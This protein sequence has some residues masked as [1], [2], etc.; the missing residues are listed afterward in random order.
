[1]KLVDFFGLFLRAT[2]RGR[3]ECV[4]RQYLMD[5]IEKDGC[6]LEFIHRRAPAF[7]DELRDFDRNVRR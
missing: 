5:G 6:S 7:L 4:T 3:G 2:E 1:M